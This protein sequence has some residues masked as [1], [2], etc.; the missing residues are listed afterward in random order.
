MKQKDK[1]QEPITIIFPDLVARVFI[2]ILEPK[3][4]EKRMQNIHKASAKILEGV[5]NEK[6]IKVCHT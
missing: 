6:S 1:Y 3:E 5:K 4:R 2:P